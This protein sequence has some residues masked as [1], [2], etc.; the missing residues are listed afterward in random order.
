[1]K[2]Q[3][4]VLVVMLL[5]ILASADDSGTCGDGLKYFFEETTG[6]LSIS[7]K[8]EGTGIM[9]NFEPSG[10]SCPWY[11]LRDKILI[12]TFEGDVISIGDYA[13]CSCHNLSS[14]TIPNSINKIGTSAFL[15]TAWYDNQPEGI[16]YAG[17][18]A[19]KYK[20]KM[21]EKTNI[22]IEEGTIGIAN[23]A[24]SNCDGLTSIHIPS[25][26]I[27]IGDRAFLGCS[28]LEVIS[29]PNNVANIG[30][31][32]L[33]NCISLSSISVDLGNSTFDSRDNCNAI[34]R[35][36]D[37][38]LIAGCKNTVIPST[39][40]NIGDHAFSSCSSISSITIPNNVI[41]IGDEAFYDC[42]ELTSI[43]IPN[44][45]NKIG[46]SAFWGTA[47]YDNQPEGIVYAGKV[48]YKYKGKMPEKTNI[49]IEEG[50]IGIAD[51]AFY[52]CSGLTSIYIPS[53]VICIGDYAFFGCSSLESITIPINVTSI[54]EG[55]F[56]GCIGLS[57]ISVDMG[58]STFDSR[59]NC[60]AIIRI[61]DNALIAGC[62]NTIIPSNITSIAGH[63]F[64][65]CRGLTSVTIPNSVTKIGGYCFY[66]CSGLTTV[67]IQNC[68][69]TIGK[70]AFHGCSGLSSI[71]IP[72]SVA[73]IGNAAFY[74][75][76]GLTSLTIGNMVKRIEDNAFAGCNSL[77]DVYCYVLSVPQTSY[78]A[79]NAS[80]INSATLH[81]SS[82]S[83]EQYKKTKPWADF[84]EVVALT[85]EDPNPATVKAHNYANSKRAD[86]Y[87]FDG[88]RIVKPQKG[89]NILKLSDGTTKKVILSTSGNRY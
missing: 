29:I 22:I 68:V 12:V 70:Y 77:G 66:Q 72:N 73:S 4:L 83:L 33:S 23:S 32:V 65:V 11:S 79:F 53:S 56:H 17:K 19:Y 40:K 34:I 58:N 82:Y 55:V 48:A 24:F 63:A 5:P 69:E 87:S 28:S 2:K 71:T 21:P 35:T 46:T 60:N 59:N 6:T 85:E 64:S 36:S 57:S 31:Y 18:V 75:C 61:S 74:G 44:S 88:H 25:S 13:F 8:G 80:S 45:I 39:V 54:G 9:S 7:K 84:K 51:K 20:G 10:S 47:W 30:K 3:L 81:V 1:M 26:V 16:V 62:K 78:N 52:D 37:N 67:T 50:T 38:T 49:I 76:S 89:L 86:I 15:G 14:I 42:S 27:C 43:T 41:T